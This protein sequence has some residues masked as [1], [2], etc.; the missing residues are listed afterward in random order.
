MKTLKDIEKEFYEIGQDGNFLNCLY[1]CRKAA[2]ELI[3]EWQIEFATIY[4]P[5]PQSNA[6]EKAFIEA[7]AKIEAFAHFFNLEEE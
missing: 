2:K 1:A 3:K 7:K 5:A 4:L 6:K